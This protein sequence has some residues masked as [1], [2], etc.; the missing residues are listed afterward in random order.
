MFVFNIV[1]EKSIFGWHIVPLVYFVSLLSFF[2]MRYKILLGKSINEIFSAS[3]LVHGT[4]AC[5]HSKILVPLD[6]S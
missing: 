5:A 3:K 2:N 4:F 1:D 6:N